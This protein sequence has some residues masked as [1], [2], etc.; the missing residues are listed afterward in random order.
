MFDRSRSRA[1]NAITAPLAVPSTTKFAPVPTLQQRAEQL[2]TTL[3]WEA[4]RTLI[5][6]AAPVLF[7]HPDPFAPTNPPIQQIAEWLVR[8]VGALTPLSAGYVQ[9]YRPTLLG[10]YIVWRLLLDGAQARVPAA[11]QRQNSRRR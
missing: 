6:A 10:L 9:A 3:P 4:C 11:A 2:A 1:T 7:G 8:E 5:E